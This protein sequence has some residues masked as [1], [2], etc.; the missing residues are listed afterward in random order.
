MFKRSGGECRGRAA[1]SAL[2][3]L[4]LVGAAASVGGSSGPAANPALLLAIGDSLVHGTMDARNNEQNTLN[5]FVQRVAD[6]LG[7]VV[8]LR[9]A[10]P[11][12]DDAEN[13][14]DPY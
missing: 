7:Q 9:F 11:L 3:A 5:A 6:S 13:R 1:A 4:C 2:G 12:Y 8:D 10:Q 14:I